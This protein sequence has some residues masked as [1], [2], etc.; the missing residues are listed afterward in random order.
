MMKQRTPFSRK[1]NH[2]ANVRHKDKT[3]NLTLWDTAGQEDVIQDYDKLRPLSYPDTNVFVIAFSVVSRTSLENAQ[4]KW[5]PEI[6]LHSPNTP[7]VLVGTKIDLRDDMKEV[8]KLKREGTEPITR[9]EGEEM[10]KKMKAY[11]FCECSAKN[12]TGLKEV[13]ATVIEAYI[14]PKK[15]K[16]GGSRSS[17]QLI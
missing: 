7:F 13:F 3:V 14:N 1:E 4:G 17:C 6:S 2:S 16:E 11:D 5:Y 12:K 15:T 8:E 9:K 10:A